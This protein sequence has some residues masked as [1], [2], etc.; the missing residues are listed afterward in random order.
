MSR[1][2][3]GPECQGL[4]DI[5]ARTSGGVFGD[6]DLDVGVRERVPPERR[7]RAS[8]PIDFSFCDGTGRRESPGNEFQRCG[9]DRGASLGLASAVSMVAF[10]YS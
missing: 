4:S 7:V 5:S 9:I 8:M 1:H 3:P 6:L 2:S 10:W